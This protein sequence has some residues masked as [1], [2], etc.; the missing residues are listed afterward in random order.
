M[1]SLC[2]ELRDSLV[3]DVAFVDYSC[4]LEVLRVILIIL[5]DEE[6]DVSGDVFAQFLGDCDWKHRRGVVDCVVNHS[7]HGVQRVVDCCR[8]RGLNLK[9]RVAADIHNQSSLA[10]LFQ[11]PPVDQASASSLETILQPFA[12]YSSSVAPTVSPYPPFTRCECRYCFNYSSGY[13]WFFCCSDTL[14]A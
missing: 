9:F 2:P 8:M 7:V 6:I 1:P 11:V 14:S 10:E 5:L 13:W 3:L 4:G 12:A